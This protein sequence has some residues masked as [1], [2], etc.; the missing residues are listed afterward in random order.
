MTSL[1][2]TLLFCAFLISILG[3]SQTKNGIKNVEQLDFYISKAKEYINKD[4]EDSIVF[5]KKKMTPLSAKKENYRKYLDFISELGHYY[6]SSGRFEKSLKVHQEG[7]AKAESF[8]DAIF[9]S[10]MEVD[11]SQTYRIFHDYNKAIEYGKKALATLGKDETKNLKQKANALDII[12]AVY[13]EINK[14]DSA[15]VYH[16]KILGFL[17]K[18]DSIDIK[19]TIVNIGYTFMNLNRLDESRRYTGRG[20]NLYKPKK[21]NY[22][23]GSMYTNIGMFGY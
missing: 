11:I 10:K 3:Y 2:K 15:L 16:K 8:N 21:H 20:L 18:L 6:E 13:N 1:K 14:P 7:I 9:K 22:I 17:P 19:A 5:F 23:S 12:A 4:I